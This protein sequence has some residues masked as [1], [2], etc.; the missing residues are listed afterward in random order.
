MVDTTFVN[1]RLIFV[2]AY[3]CL[4]AGLM[5]L[6]LMPISVGTRWPGPD[7][8][9]VITFAWVL[10]RPRYVPVTIVAIVFLMADILFMRPLGLWAALMVLSV[11]FLRL[12]EPSMREKPF[13]VEWAS[14]ATTLLI[15]TVAYRL[16]LTISLVDPPAISLT[17]LQYVL[18][19]LAYPVVILVSRFIFGVNKMTL[20]QTD[21]TGR[22]R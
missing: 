15:A 22:Q 12:R 1:R 10:R 9:V 19:V 8:L 21:A 13:P 11:E 5:L 14:V 2:L 18:T 20:S 6:N 4:A 3:L 7:L 16:I 17:F